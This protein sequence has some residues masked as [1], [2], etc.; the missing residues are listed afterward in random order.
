LNYFV[1]EPDSCS[2]SIWL[3]FFLVWLIF[4]L[5][6]NYFVFELSVRE[7]SREKE[8]IWRGEIP[9]HPP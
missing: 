3:I 9:Q 8:K 5:D 6:F 7:I 4:S 1:F 2:L